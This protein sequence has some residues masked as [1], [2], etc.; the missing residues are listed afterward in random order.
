[1]WNFLAQAQNWPFSSA[2]AL[3]LLIALFELVGL[4][5]GAGLSD[6]IDSM[7]PDL[8]VDVDV[9]LDGAD[10]HAPS[11][12]AHLLGWLHV[13]EVPA[14]MILVAFLTC[15]GLLGLILQ[16]SIA[17]ILG[18]ALPAWLAAVIVLPLSLFPMR[19]VSGLLSKIMPKDET[20]AVSSQSFIGR[21]AVI[22]LGEAK[23]GSPAQAKLKDRYGHTHYIMVEP[24]DAAEC[25]KSGEELL[26][27]AQNSGVFQAI[28]NTSEALSNL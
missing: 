17:G 16:S 21:V 7:L 15:F 12:F 23:L 27:V 28:R 13:G 5:L 24:D 10:A 18:S 11:L 19:I 2:L 4:V 6:M 20:E 25:F 14:L 26:L 3:M 22:T 8:H 1:M 9:A